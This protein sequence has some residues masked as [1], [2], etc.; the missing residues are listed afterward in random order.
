MELLKRETE[1]IVSVKLP[2]GSVLQWLNAYL[3]RG[4]DGYTLLDAGMPDEET[5]GLWQQAWR[6]LGISPRDI[7]SIII[8]HH[9]VDHYGLAARLQ[10]VTG[11]SVR[12][13]ESCFLQASRIWSGDSVYDEEV[14]ELFARHGA[15]RHLLEVTAPE[16]KH[17]VKSV[18][19][20]PDVEFIRAGDK[21]ALGKS[22][23]EAELVSGHA[24]GHLCLYD[25]QEQLV[26]CGDHVIP[27]MLPNLNFTL[28]FDENPLGS[29]FS[30]LKEHAELPVRKAYPGHMIPFRKYNARAADI[31]AQYRQRIDDILARMDKPMTAFEL[32]CLVF[33]VPVNAEQLRFKLFEMLA[34]LNYL[35]SLNLIKPAEAGADGRLYYRRAPVHANRNP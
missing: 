1:E 2:V 20:H 6:H 28:G 31:A 4:E 15:P 21:L 35:Q 13:T 18:N 3:I 30:S 5:F 8:T 22:I 7:T 32:C 27:K 14:L 19:V 24:E 16:L 26:F 33:F 34:C 23:F 25:K 11:A 17:Y 29:Y 12:M 9:H 10:E